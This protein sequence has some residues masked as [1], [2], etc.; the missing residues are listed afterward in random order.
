MGYAERSRTDVFLKG[1][2]EIF[3]RES[4]RSADRAIL[5]SLVLLAQ[6]FRLP[7]CCHRS[8]H[9]SSAANYGEPETPQRVVFP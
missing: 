8:P 2:Q 7:P 3:L 4:A 6:S 5:L 1:I 9:V